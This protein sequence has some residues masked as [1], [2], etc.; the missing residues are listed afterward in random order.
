[1]AASITKTSA[2]FLASLLCLVLLSEVGMLMAQAA[3]AP[4]PAPAP[5]AASHGS[6]RCATKHVWHAATG[7]PITVCRLG[8]QLPG[9]PAAATPRSRP[10]TS[11]SALRLAYFLLVFL[12]ETGRLLVGK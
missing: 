10:I 1:M 6:R 11:T 8:L 4:A 3:P 5:G 2:L 9:I 12:P 7:V